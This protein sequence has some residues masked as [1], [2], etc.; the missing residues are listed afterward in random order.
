EER[1]NFVEYWA[2]YVRTHS[3]KEWSRQQNVLINSLMQNAK[4]SKM[5]PQQYLK[6]KGEK[7][8]R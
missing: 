2:N 8:F 5:T 7:C 6:I 1:M 3:D 4:N